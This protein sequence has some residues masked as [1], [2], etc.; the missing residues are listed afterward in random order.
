MA[1]V[2]THAGKAHAD[3]LLAAAL[4]MAHYEDI[5]EIR[6]V[7]RYD[8]KNIDKRE[9][10]WLLD[11]G[12]EYVPEQRKLDHHQGVE[13]SHPVCSATLALRELYPEIVPGRNLDAARRGYYDKEMR[14]LVP[15]LSNVELWDTAGPAAF[16]DKYDT[17]MRSI[18]HK[19]INPIGNLFAKAVEGVLK[20]TRESAVGCVLIRMGRV[21][22]KTIQEEGPGM[23]WLDENVKVVDTEKGK[24]IVVPPVDSFHV[25]KLRMRW[26]RKRIG[27]K[28]L[29]VIISVTKKGVT[30][31]FH[32]D[33]HPAVNLKKLEGYPKLQ[34]VHAEGFSAAIESTD[35]EELKDV[36]RLITS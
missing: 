1:V 23:K 3:E 14:D 36:I 25:H 26:V 18:I 5:S 13:S 24:F 16:A 19:Q 17:T 22:I 4:L 15:W 28:N 34:F 21:I 2:Y 29:A 35:P 31:F 30:H 12:E 32:V 27:T 9:E 6:R 11:I 8:M 20:I 10:D 33:K 7:R